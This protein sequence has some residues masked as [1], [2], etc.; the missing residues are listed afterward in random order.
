MNLSTKNACIYA[1]ISKRW[2][3]R[4]GVLKQI[5][6]IESPTADAWLFPKKLSFKVAGKTIGLNALYQSQDD[7]FR[8]H[9]QGFK[10][11]ASMIH[12]RDGEFDLDFIHQY[13]DQVRQCYGVVV[14]EEFGFDSEIMRVLLRI[15]DELEGILFIHDSIMNGS[16]RVMFG[17]LMHLV[18][19]DD[20]AS[21]S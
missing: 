12:E 20:S 19:D 5:K 1:D 11:W 18:D 16:G 6:G 21:K 4:P 10:G 3:L 14:D 8:E 13:L 9:I 15:T 7:D 2:W 17:N